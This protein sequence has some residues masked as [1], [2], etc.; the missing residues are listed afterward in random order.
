MGRMIKVISTGKN[1]TK[2]SQL[3]GIRAFRARIPNKAFDTISQPT[4]EINTCLGR[5]K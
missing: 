1:N 2:E 3:I 5:L 4:A